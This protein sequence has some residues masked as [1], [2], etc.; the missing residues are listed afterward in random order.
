MLPSTSAIPINL[1][2]SPV[3]YLLAKYPT[4][5]KPWTMKVFPERP[6]WTFSFFAIK[7][8]VINNLVAVKIPKPVDSGLPLIPPCYSNFPVVT[9]S[10]LMSFWP[11]KA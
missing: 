4:L 10:A 5:P 7:G 6:G 11:K 9:A 8:L 3:K 2:P 1:H